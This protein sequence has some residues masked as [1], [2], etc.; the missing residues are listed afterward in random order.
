[1]I[2]LK[3][4]T[5]YTDIYWNPDTFFQFPFLAFF[6]DIQIHCHFTVVQADAL[7]CHRSTTEVAN[8]STFY[9]VL[10]AADLNGFL[11]H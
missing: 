11:S 5:E 2:I 10:I 9:L 3:M 7:K 4:N 6:C 8:G 1:M